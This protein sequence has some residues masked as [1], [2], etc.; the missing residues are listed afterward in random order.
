M[1]SG[2]VAGPLKRVAPV[3]RK[4]R[5]TQLG[6]GAFIALVEQLGRDG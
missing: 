1:R 6:S 2:P 4:S 5:R 3:P